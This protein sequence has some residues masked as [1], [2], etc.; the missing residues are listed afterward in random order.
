M[1]NAGGG[2]AAMLEVSMAAAAVEASVAAA[3]VA[4][5]GETAM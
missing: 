1:D 5:V 2:E 3:V 4:I